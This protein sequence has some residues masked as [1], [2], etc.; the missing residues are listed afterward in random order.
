ME[1]LAAAIPAAELASL[2]K[3]G[4]TISAF[5]ADYFANFP[6]LELDGAA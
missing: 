1:Q 6:V 4:E 2:M 3:E 5:E